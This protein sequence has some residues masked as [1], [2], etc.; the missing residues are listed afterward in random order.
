MSETSMWL[1]LGFLGALVILAAVLFV[2]Q[3]ETQRKLEED[4]FMKM[5]DEI[6]N[7]QLNRKD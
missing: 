1:M 3:S 7:T 5:M 4:R 6:D 2:L